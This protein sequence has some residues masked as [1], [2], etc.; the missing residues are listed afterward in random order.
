MGHEHFVLFERGF[1]QAFWG[2]AAIPVK[3]C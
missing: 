3:V 2:E 1:A